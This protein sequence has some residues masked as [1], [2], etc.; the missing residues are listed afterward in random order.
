VTVGQAADFTVKVTFKDKP[1]ATK[2]IDFVK[3]LVI[4]ATGNIALT[5]PAKAV[6]DGEWT[7]SLTA[8]QTSKLATGSNRVEVVVVSKLV[9][10]P[11]FESLTFVTIK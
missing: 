9:A 2:D 11:V 7:A 3:F 4:D 1:Y 8:D 6:K 10:M 5:A